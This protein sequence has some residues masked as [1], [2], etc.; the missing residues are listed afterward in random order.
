MR[1]VELHVSPFCAV[2]TPKCPNWELAN[3]SIHDLVAW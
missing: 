2:N 3:N 1:Q